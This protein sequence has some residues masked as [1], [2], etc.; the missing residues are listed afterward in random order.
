MKNSTLK[1]TSSELVKITSE[2]K[3]TEPIPCRLPCG[4]KY[5]SKK[6]SRDKQNI[7]SR[8]DFFDN[9]I[10]KSKSDKQPKENT[11]EDKTAA[12]TEKIPEGFFDD[13][14]ADAK[15]IKKC[16]ISML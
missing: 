10:K 8:K 16:K 4:N 15:V 14:K 12:T 9:G 13:P 6:L 3:I 7:F 11:K 2:A 5:L 1:N